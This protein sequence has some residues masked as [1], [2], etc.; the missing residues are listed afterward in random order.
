M[1][2]L[3][4]AIFGIMVFAILCEGLG[5]IIGIAIGIIKAINEIIEERRNQ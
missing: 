1:T 4:C 3:L 5:A 2:L